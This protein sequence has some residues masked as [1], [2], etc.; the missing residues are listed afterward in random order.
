MR[1]CRCLKL[2]R[3]IT[4]STV[5]VRST[6]G[7]PTLQSQYRVIPTETT[8]KRYLRTGNITFERPQITAVSGAVEVSLDQEEIERRLTIPQETVDNVVDKVNTDVVNNAS[9]LF[10]VVYIQRKQFKV[11]TGDLIQ[12]IDHIEA[13]VG[14]KIRLEKILMVGGDNFSIFGRPLLSRDLVHVWAT[15]LE[16]TTTPKQIFF[17]KKRRKGFKRWVEYKDDLTVLRINTIEVVPLK[18]NTE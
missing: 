12:T 16:K 10:A 5:N 1:I 3:L 2:T 11:T 14:Q 13:D 17:Q 4:T 7:L 15:V 18:D 6:A 9:R 8:L